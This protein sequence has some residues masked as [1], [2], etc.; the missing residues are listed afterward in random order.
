MYERPRRPRAITTD[1]VEHADFTAALA[2]A[3][4]HDPDVRAAILR[5]LTTARA[6]RP[7]P[8]ITPP[9]RQTGR[10]R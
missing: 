7:R 1:D 5:L 3:I 4:D 9:L 6:R 2:E 8:T 10:G